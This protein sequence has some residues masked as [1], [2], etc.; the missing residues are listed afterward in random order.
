VGARRVVCG[1][2]IVIDRIVAGGWA[3]WIIPLVAGFVGWWT[4]AVA[5]RMM[6][7]PTEFVGLKPWFGWQ[8]IIPASAMDLAARFTRLVTTR[9]LTVRELFARFDAAQM[10]KQLAPALDRITDE[11]LDQVVARHA[12]AAWQALP[13]EGRAMMRAMLRQE[14]D[15]T[16]IAIFG[17]LLADVEKIIDFEKIVMEAVARDKRL[18]SELF[19]TVGKQEFAFVKASGWYFGLPFGMVQMTL[20]ALWPVWWSLPVAGFAVGYATNWLAMKLIFYPKTPLRIGP[21]SI[22]GVF[23]KRQRQVAELYAET[24]SA[25]VLSPENIVRTVTSGAHGELLAAIVRRHVGA[26]LDKY[27]QNPMLAGL[28]PEAGRAA[29]RLELQA[30]VASELPRPDG[31]VHQFVAHAM[32]IQGELFARMTQLD[33]ESFEGVLRPAFEQDEW[34]LIVV[35]AVLG[36]AAGF[37]QLVACFGDVWKAAF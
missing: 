29:I 14:A 36:L 7:Q 18:I 17:D 27:E 32:D 31:V 12:G 6:F 33:P 28:V 35:G 30:R 11:A 15:A 24:I 8:G 9:L 34:K 13:P 26:L 21:W 1:S 25:R 19:L 22:Q 2:V 23:H 20:W 37:V 10:V 16:A 4:N 3:L 5:V